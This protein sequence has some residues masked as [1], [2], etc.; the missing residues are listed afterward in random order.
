M[1]KHDL[2]VFGLEAPD[3]LDLADVI[4]GGYQMDHL[5]DTND[6]YRAPAPRLPENAVDGWRTR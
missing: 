5:Q 2:E 1:Q 3:L 6:S 4:F